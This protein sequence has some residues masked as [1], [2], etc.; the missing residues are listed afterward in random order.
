M[1]YIDLWLQGI[2]SSDDNIWYISKTGENRLAFE[3]STQDGQFDFIEPMIDSKGDR[4]LLI[5]KKDS[6]LWTLDL[7][8]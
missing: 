1:D 5:N 7:E 2:V 6:S 4:M 8:D 3:P